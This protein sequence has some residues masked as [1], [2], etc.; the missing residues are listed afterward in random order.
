M[1]EKSSMVICKFWPDNILT[2]LLSFH[3]LAKQEVAFQRE[4][5]VL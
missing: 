4:N 5:S 3:N 2:S 1:E